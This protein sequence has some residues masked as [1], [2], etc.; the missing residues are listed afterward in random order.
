MQ[1]H[2]QRQLVS[3]GLLQGDLEYLV[4]N[5]LH[6][7]EFNSKMGNPQDIVTVSFKVKDVMPAN[8]LVS[9]LENGYD[10]V[11]DAD[12]STGEVADG[13]RLVFVEMQRTPEI[14]EYLQELLTDLDHLT[15]VKLNEWKFRWFKQQQYEDFSPERLRKIVPASPE[16]YMES[17]EHFMQVEAE[18]K[19]LNQDIKR[20]RQ[21]S[22][23]D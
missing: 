18:N 9:F 19:R 13:N 15:G 14:Y 10:W 11:L 7:D 21:L 6:F 12:V 5:T 2:P 8:D 20:I 1:P 22:G 3:E 23:L 17:V 4:D 16:S